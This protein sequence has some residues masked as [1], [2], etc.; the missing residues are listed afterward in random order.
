ML[1]SNKPEIVTNAGRRLNAIEER[2]G[3]GECSLANMQLVSVGTIL[4]LSE[5]YL[6]NHN[7]FMVIGGV[8]HGGWLIA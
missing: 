3:N 5:K 4:E 6:I 1:F 2:V 8:G 7:E